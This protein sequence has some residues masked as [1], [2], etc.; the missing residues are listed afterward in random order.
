[1]SDASLLSSIQTRIIKAIP[2]ERE[3]S[4]APTL[5]AVSKTKPVEAIQEL[6]DQGHRAFAENRVQEA[7][8]KFP[9]LKAQH[10]DL[11]LHLIG[12]LQ[13]NKCKDAVALF[14]A[15]H[16]VD[17]EK[18][19]RSLKAEMDKQGRQL[20]CFIQV[21]AGEEEQKA[22]VLPQDLQALYKVCFQIGLPV[23]GLMCIPPADEEPTPHFGLL[24]VLAE[25]LGLKE[26]SMGMS[27]DFETAVQLGATYVRVGSALFGARD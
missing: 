2:P 21:N 5:L 12:P 1:M 20:P 9:E 23:V 8:S 17:R 16:S 13:T 24:R 22:G 19:A 27:G 7:Q 26:L 25:R 18:L 4:S 6:I 3:H 15:I 10:A 11:E 14:D